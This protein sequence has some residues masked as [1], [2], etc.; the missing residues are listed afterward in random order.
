MKELIE[1]FI[2][3][4]E[5]DPST[6]NAWRI[7]DALARESR[8]TIDS[9]DPEQREFDAAWLL[10]VCQP[11]EKRGYDYA[12]NWFTVANP[13]RFLKSRR[14]RIEA[15][16]L[17]HGYKQCLELKKR[18]SRGRHKTTW[19]LDTYE[20]NGDSNNDD[21]SLANSDSVS[22]S[23]IRPPEIK[24]GLLG[25]VIL[26]RGEF[27]ARSGRG[28]FLATLMILSMLPILALFI[29]SMSM[30]ALKRAVQVDDVISLL[31]LAAIY[32]F[33]WQQ[34]IRPW[35]LLLDDRIV[36]AGGFFTTWMEDPAQ[37]EMAMSDK[38]RYI[39][40]VRYTATCPICSGDIELK[41]GSGS[42]KR[43]IFGCCT[44]VPQEHVFTFDRITQTGTR[45][46]T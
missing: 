12:K 41:Y 23:A 28:A 10:E 38:Y 3:W 39:R 42:N 45:Y 40:L 19:F 15:H 30:L 37:L 1:C 32:T 24:I 14:D 36:L 16:F 31:L 33:Y 29:L 13:H 5:S 7:V 46:Q 26:G 21:S 8:K 25:R 11:G 2:G 43:R 17:N 6:N 4:L 18:E 34:I 22:Y 20:I 27:I 9:K 44:E 35:L